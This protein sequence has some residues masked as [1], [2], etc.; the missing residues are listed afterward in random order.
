[1]GKPVVQG[2]AQK[3]PDKLYF[4]IGEVSDLTGVQPHVLRYWESEFD[5]VSPQKSKSNQRLYRR[6][7]VELILEIKRLLYDE[8]FTIAGA[9]KRL[10]RGGGGA[11]APAPTAAATP[12]AAPASAGGNGRP[13]KGV[14]QGS[15]DFDGGRFRQEAKAIKQELEELLE[16]LKK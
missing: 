8:K 6:K 1:M 9:R 7:D 10:S 13:S 12:S 14:V 4:R 16:L 15:F 2:Q 3:I 11:P 5:I